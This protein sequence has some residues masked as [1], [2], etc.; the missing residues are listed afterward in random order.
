MINAFPSATRLR[1]QME[2]RYEEERR[3]G[4]AQVEALRKRAAEKEAALQASTAQQIAAL[5]G[6]VQELQG[7]L[8]QRIAAADELAGTAKQSMQVCPGQRPKCLWSCT[9]S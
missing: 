6:Q 1:Q 5:T 8:R 7:Q 2:T 4:L 3:K 9:C